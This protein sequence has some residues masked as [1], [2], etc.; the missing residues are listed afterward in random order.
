MEANNTKSNYSFR[1]TF[2]DVFKRTKKFK[3][4]ILYYKDIYLIPQQNNKKKLI[5]KYPINKNIIS[6]I[7]VNSDYNII[8]IIIDGINKYQ[9]I[10]NTH[11]KCKYIIISIKKV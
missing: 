9:K 7:G 11:I 4:K 3:K 1:I 10:I 6:I 8:L 2:L 5:V